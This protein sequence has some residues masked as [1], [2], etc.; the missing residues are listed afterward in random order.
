MADKGYDSQENRDTLS[1]MKLKSRIMHKAQ[2]N[3]RLTERETAMNK[4]IAKC[5]MPWKGHM[6]P[7]A[8]GSVL[9]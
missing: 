4:A 6:P 7:C 2:K 3:R 5:V 1:R 9:E 8:D